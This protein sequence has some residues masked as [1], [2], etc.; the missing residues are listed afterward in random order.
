MIGNHQQEQ[1]YAQNVGENGQLHVGDHF[2]DS[3]TFYG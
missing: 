1:K 2:A 3:N